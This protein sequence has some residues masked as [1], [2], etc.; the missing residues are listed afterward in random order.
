MPERKVFSFKMS[1]LNT[2]QH[3]T[4]VAVIQECY[5]YM[6]IMIVMM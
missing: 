6:V 1:S 3:S 2:G 4:V 5:G